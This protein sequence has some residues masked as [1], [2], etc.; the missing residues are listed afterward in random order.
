M[1]QEQRP[2]G[3]MA[4]SRVAA[5]GRERMFL[6][7]TLPAPERNFKKE[8]RGGGWGVGGLG[9]AI[10]LRKKVIRAAGPPS[11]PGCP[12]A[13]QAWGLALP[14]PLQAVTWGCPITSEPSTPSA[15]EWSLVLL[16]SQTTGRTRS[17]QKHSA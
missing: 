9:A 10:R 7:E 13:S 15:P 16:T 2:L 11:S 6:P 5:L 1:S 17:Q 12:G 8:I 4:V 3:R 14:P